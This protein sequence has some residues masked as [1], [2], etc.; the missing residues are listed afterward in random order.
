MLLDEV[1]AFLRL[2]KIGAAFDHQA[3]LEPEKVQCSIFSEYIW[4]PGKIIVDMGE[5]LQSFTRKLELLESDIS[6]GRLLRFSTLKTQA[7]VTDLMVDFI[8]RLWAHF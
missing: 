8:K 7:Q 6:S 5:K 1:K 3:L 4:P 2:S